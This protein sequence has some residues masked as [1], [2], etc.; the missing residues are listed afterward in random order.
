MTSQKR[1]SG[2]FYRYAA[3]GLLAALFFVIVG[4]GG[5]LAW[6]KWQGGEVANVFTAEVQKR[7][8]AGAADRTKS[9]GNRDRT[10]PDGDE[11]PG[12][13]TAGSE[14]AEAYKTSTE[15]NR[16]KKW[17][18]KTFLEKTGECFRVSDSDEG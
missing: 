7:S 10:T 9:A 3:Y 15:S 2:R 4:A 18:G 11:F 12:N 5:V 14:S 6:M 17:K 16:G 8:G 13:F 1:K